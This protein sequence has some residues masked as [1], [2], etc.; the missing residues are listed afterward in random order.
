MLEAT[1][2]FGALIF[3]GLAL[4]FLKLPTRATL[5]LLGYAIWLDVGVTALALWIHWGTVT[6]LMAA[7]VAGLACSLA[8]TIGRHTVGYVRRGVYHPGWLQL[9][10]Q[11][12]RETDLRLRATRNP[13]AH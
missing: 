8:T 7:T 11:P 4:I 6:G 2:V 10:V 1:L 9:P 5:L 3:A 12:G 13:R